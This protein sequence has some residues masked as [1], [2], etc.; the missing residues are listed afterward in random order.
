MGNLVSKKIDFSKNI[1]IKICPIYYQYKNY[2]DFLENSEK[3]I[4][5]YKKLTKNDIIRFITKQ[6]KN[7][8]Y[9]LEFDKNNNYS[10]E[11]IKID[12]NYIIINIKYK[13]ITK[14]YNILYYKD[15][16]NDGFYKYFGSGD[17]LTIKKCN[18]QNNIYFHMG[19]I[20]D[21]Y[22]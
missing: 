21:V 10:I 12:K 5:S 19:Q 9:I 16:I 22:Q 3:Y 1:Y 8:N 4:I 17:L 2:D 15:W 11:N 18:K 13:N 20:F 14:N 6:L 7:N